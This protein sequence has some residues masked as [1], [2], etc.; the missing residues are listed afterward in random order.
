MNH[1]NTEV[2]RQ[3]FSTEKNVN[4]LQDKPCGMS[5]PSLPYLPP[6]NNEFF[7]SYGKDDLVVQIIKTFCLSHRFFCTISVVLNITS[8]EASFHRTGKQLRHQI[9]PISTKCFLRRTDFEW[10]LEHA[11]TKYVS[12][13]FIAANCIMWFSLNAESW[14][15]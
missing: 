13:V 14:K 4:I 12:F 15:E 3:D 11:K 2:W 9:D 8:A 10:M 1:L 7:L 5:R 6:K